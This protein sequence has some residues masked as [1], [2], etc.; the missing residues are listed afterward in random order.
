MKFKNLHLI[1]ILA[2]GLGLVTLTSNSGGKTG[3]ST[4]GC[5]GA[6]C[7]T[8][9]TATSVFISFDGNSA[10]TSYTPGKKYAIQVSITNSSYSGN[11]NA[12]AGF[13]LTATKGSISNIISGTNHTSGEMNHT[14]PKAL[15][16]G[17][18]NFTFDW[19]APVTG[20]GNA[21]FNIAGN[22][23]NGDNGTTGDAWDKTTKTLTEEVTTIVKKATIATIV[24]SAITNTGATI[25]AQINAN[26]ASTAAEV[27]YGTATTYG[28]T[29]AMTPAS[30]T[31]S[32]ATSASA[33]LTGLLA[34]TIYNY[35]IKATNSAGDTFTSN[36]TFK[37]TATGAAIFQSNKETIAIY[38]NPAS[39]Y[40]I[41]KG[42]NI[43]NDFEFSL[44]NT[45]GKR[46]SLPIV[47]TNADEIKLNTSNLSKGIYYI[48]WNE[49]GKRKSL[50]L[51]IEH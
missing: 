10:L 16:S 49:N 45:T 22:I 6:G 28:I 34:N 15:S 17:T 25:S 43:A 4:T 2:A 33:S 12:K 46:L 1:Y 13:N 19:T 7:H 50:P 11:A 39:N 35:R 8:A 21:V 47:S 5:G 40:T 20:S 41:I 9:S 30:I 37:T 51:D 36:S 18:T 24:S 44:I 42:E 14:T 38:P 32:S 29:K 31:G 26:N 48:Q 3:A 23:V 27:Q